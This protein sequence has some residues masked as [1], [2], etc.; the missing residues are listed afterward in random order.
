[1]AERLSHLGRISEAVGPIHISAFDHRKELPMLRR[2]MGILLRDPQYPSQTELTPEG[3]HRYEPGEGWFGPPDGLTRERIQLAYGKLQDAHSL[4]DKKDLYVLST[5]LLMLT[6]KLKANGRQ[7]WTH[8]E[9]ARL[10]G[11]IYVLR[12]LDNPN[13]QRMLNAG[14]KAED[15]VHSEAA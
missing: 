11:K 7:G 4:L 2:G 8:P 14:L 3:L 10:E 15:Q 13:V 9:L 6:I 1:M 12:G 5:G